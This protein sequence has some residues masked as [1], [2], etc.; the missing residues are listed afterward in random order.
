MLAT[1]R[2]TRALF[3]RFPYAWIRS[4]FWP[5]LRYAIAEAIHSRHQ[6]WFTRSSVRRITLVAIASVATMAFSESTVSPAATPETNLPLLV[7]NL[8]YCA[9][10]NSSCNDTVNDL[11]DPKTSHSSARIKHVAGYN[12][13]AGKED[14]GDATPNVVSLA[15]SL[16]AES[17]SDSGVRSVLALMQRIG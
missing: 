10:A 6:P 3:R 11:R 5:L 12:V 4:I 8:L 15:A 1:N 17:T 14:L 7:H 13:T 9:M 2:C 16:S